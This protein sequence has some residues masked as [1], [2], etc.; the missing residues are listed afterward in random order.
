MVAR[1]SSRSIASLAALV[2]ATSSTACATEIASASDAETIGT[3]EEAITNGDDDSADPAVV[4]LLLDGQVLCSGFLVASHVVVTA[5][6][7]LD[8]VEP[9]TVYFGA[10]PRTKKGT[11]IK[12]ADSK[13]HPDYDPATLVNDVGVIGL[14][15]AAPT[16]PLPVRVTPLDDTFV[17]MQV[18]LVG[19]GARQGGGVALSKHVGMTEMTSVADQD[20]RFKPSP[21]QTCEGDS[22]G[23]A[24][25]TIDGKEL[26]IGITSS[27]DTDCKAYGNDMR[28]DVFVPWVAGYSKAY[29]APAAPAETPGCATA[30]PIPGASAPSWLVVAIA[31]ALAACGRRRRRA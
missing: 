27:G 14:A 9:D 24:F 7:C 18:R 20:M 5:A 23:P 28:M 11:F 8:Q 12:V 15:T 21:S 30:A 25:A 6:H 1:W 26:V 17:G 10:N 3:T 31:C 16:K 19:F 22:G 13:T 4:A 2:A 29:R